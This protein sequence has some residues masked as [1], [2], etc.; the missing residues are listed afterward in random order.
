MQDRHRGGGQ[1]DRDRGRG[2]EPGHAGGD[3]PSGGAQEDRGKGGAAA[4]AAQAEADAV[5]VVVVADT[6][7][8]YADAASAAAR[9]DV[10]RS[11]VGLLDESLRLTEKRHDAGLEDGLAVARIRTLRDQRSADI[12][13][14]ETERR[15][16]LFALATLTGRAPADYRLLSL[17]YTERFQAQDVNRVAV[18][19]S[20]LIGG[21]SLVEG[22]TPGCGS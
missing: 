22:A 9:E 8:A 21:V 11:I 6:T 1:A 15:A 18:M 5:R 17:R 2:R 20:G 16:A 7:R 13:A 3:E 4:E 10:A 19:P 12:P 14:I